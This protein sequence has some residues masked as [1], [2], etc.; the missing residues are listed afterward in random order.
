MLVHGFRSL[1]VH[2]TRGYA[3]STP[4]GSEEEKG[5]MMAEEKGSKLESEGGQAEDGREFDQEHYDRHGLTRTNTDRHGQAQTNTDQ[6]EECQS[7][8]WRCQRHTKF[9]GGAN[10]TRSGGME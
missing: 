3:Y 4:T 8:D 5:E 6:H 1:E 9:V 2:C 10:G 7:G